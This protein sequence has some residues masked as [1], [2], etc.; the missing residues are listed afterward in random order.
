VVN[1]RISWVL[2]VA[3]AVV[4]A[5]LIAG[6]GGGGEETADANETLTK[7]EFIKQG[8]EIC[9]EVGRQREE[10]M[11]KFGK[12]NGFTL[13]T[14][15]KKQ[16][17]E[18]VTEVAIQTLRQQTEKFRALGLPVGEEEEAEAII[19]AWE[20]ATKEVESNPGIAVVEDPLDAADALARDYGFKFCGLK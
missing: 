1:G 18:L 12:E 5:V 11:E 8:D 3:L 14:A 2:L 10:Q 19:V 6:C 15:N 16:L 13:E 20:S 17:E 4:S 9:K 7:A